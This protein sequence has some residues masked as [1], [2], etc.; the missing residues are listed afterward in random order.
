MDRWELT[1]TRRNLAAREPYLVLSSDALAVIVS[2]EV[3]SPPRVE[4]GSVDRD[5]TITDCQEVELV[6]ADSDASIMDGNV[7]S[8][9]PGDTL[10]RLADLTKR[11]LV[12]LFP[13]QRDL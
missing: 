4:I 8:P 6:S 2:R 9:A 1:I 13:T 10:R 12:Q 5:G 7:L 3:G 11:R